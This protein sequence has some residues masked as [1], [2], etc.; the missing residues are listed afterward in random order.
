MA[1]WPALVAQTTTR[2]WTRRSPLR[3]LERRP[4]LGLLGL[5][6]LLLALALVLNFVGH[7]RS[8]TGP[9]P[10]CEHTE[11][12]AHWWRRRCTQLSPEPGMTVIQV[13]DR[14]AQAAAH[15]RCGCAN[16]NSGAADLRPSP[17]ATPPI[18]SRRTR[19]QVRN[20]TAEQHRCGRGDRM[21]VCAPKT[22][23][24]ACPKEG[25]CA[26]SHSSDDDFHHSLADPST[27]SDWSGI[28][29]HTF[30]AIRL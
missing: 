4:A 30:H 28:A 11:P 21:C 14:R 17:F 29:S 24:C 9:H 25:D 20:A 15:C 1:A 8:G 3:I 19:G 22:H 6:F 26:E 12:R 16:T 13:A 27:Q 7:I 10:T 2:R 23:Q 18:W 5:C